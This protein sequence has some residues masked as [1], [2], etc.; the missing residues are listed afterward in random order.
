MDADDP[1][2]VASRWPVTAFRAVAMVET[3]TYLALLAAVVARRLPDG[4][5]VV[6]PVGLTH[7]LVF[8]VYLVGVLLVR[9]PLGWGARR[10]T[11]AVCAAAIPL[12]AWRVEREV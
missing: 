9:R 11:W 2:G 5:D 8:L 12:G 7:G 4:P 10:T 3:T 6:F 1:A